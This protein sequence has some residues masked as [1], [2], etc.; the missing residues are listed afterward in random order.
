MS[1]LLTCRTRQEVGEG[2]WSWFANLSPIPKTRHL[3][4]DGMHRS[5]SSR[6]LGGERYPAT[7]RKREGGVG[8]VGEKYVDN[9]GRETEADAG[10]DVMGHRMVERCGFPFRGK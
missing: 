1:S 7:E 6:S 2:V 4:N 9:E 5:V 8:G 10:K 3:R